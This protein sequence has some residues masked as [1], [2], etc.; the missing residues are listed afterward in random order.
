MHFL[1]AKGKEW[2]YNNEQL[3]YI[4]FLVLWISGISGV[5]LSP[6]FS[7]VFNGFDWMVSS[8]FKLL[9]LL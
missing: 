3:F 6:I 7:T 9:G 8:I 2:F 4:V 5:I 1:T